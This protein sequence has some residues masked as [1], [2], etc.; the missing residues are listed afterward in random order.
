MSARSK[1]RVGVLRGGKSKKHHQSVKTGAHVLKNISE[2]YIPI[3]IFIDQSGVWHVQGV[4]ADIAKVAK[5][6]DVIFNAT[7]GTQGEE[8]NLHRQLD[9]FQIPY[10]G[11]GHIASFFAGQEL[12]SKKLLKQQ[13][14]RSPHHKVFTKEW[15]DKNSRMDLWRTV[16]NP[17]VVRST[18]FDSVKGTSIVQSF[19]ELEPALAKAFEYGSEVVFEEFIKGREASCVVIDQLRDKEIYTLFPVELVLPTGMLF[20]DH[21][22]NS[23]EKIKMV[24]PGKFTELEKF[25]IQDMA[26]KVHEALGLRHYSRSNFIVSPTRGVYFKEV[27][28]LPSLVADSS[29]VEALKSIGLSFS[30]FL[31]HT[32]KLALNGRKR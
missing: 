8:L 25:Q 15:I 7:H 1:I 13:G 21:S 20:F 29:F 32:I 28:T 27:S 11:S 4:K 3:D 23:D 30:A 5:K 31:D 10:T 17:S 2:N 9:L 18:M 14:I 24:S 12:H 6:I 19:L 16:T 22:E 26:K